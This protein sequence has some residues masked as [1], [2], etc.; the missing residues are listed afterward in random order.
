MQKDTK[1]NEMSLADQITLMT[2][3]AQFPA[4]TVMVFHRTRIGLRAININ[5]MIIMAI[6]MM[7]LVAGFPK[8]FLPHTFLAPVY[9]ITMLGISL[10]VRYRRWNELVSGVRWH[11]RCSGQSLLERLPW[12][13]FMRRQHRIARFADP[14]AVA[15]VG[16][17]LAGLSHGLG[18]WVIFSAF[19]LYVME[20][21]IFQTQLNRE[22]DTLDGLFDSEVQSEVAQRYAGGNPNAITASPTLAETSGVPTGVSGDIAKQIALRRA[23]RI[24][25]TD[26]IAAQGGTRS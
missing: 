3:L 9:A 16:G 26:N 17:L 8:F 25:V 2:K 18:L 14:A 11:T 20:A 13:T 21:D 24:A 7:V 22:L 10:I 12:P 15:I 1:F 19:W 23:K 5:A 6:V 4:L